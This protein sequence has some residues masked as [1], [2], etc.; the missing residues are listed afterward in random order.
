MITSLNPAHLLSYFPSIWRTQ[1][2]NL[3]TYSPPTS[4]ISPLYV[5][6]C[7]FAES[8]IT[9]PALWK[10]NGENLPLADQLHQ[11]GFCKGTQP[12]VQQ[13]H[14]GRASMPCTAELVVLYYTPVTP[15][16]FLPVH[17]II[18]TWH[19]CHILS[20]LSC[21]NHNSHLNNVNHHNATQAP[22]P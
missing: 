10:S 11:N 5:M 18:I 9:A 16:L 19:A 1:S 20:H 14:L 21:S 8:Q 4:Q 22:S 3:T 13:P 6:Y 12:V 15:A 17:L 2:L 7:Y